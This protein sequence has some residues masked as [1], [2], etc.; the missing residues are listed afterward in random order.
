M[1]TELEPQ[2]IEAIAQRVIEK[3]KPMLSDNGKH[4]DNIV[5]NKNSLSEYLNVSES[6]I[7]KLISNK[8]IPHFKIQQGQ[9]G[10]VRFSKKDIDRWIQR[11]T[12][13]EI[14]PF[15]IKAVS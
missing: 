12:I 11:H 10:G 8:Q 13:P 7:N 4:E 9:S 14:N 15:T 5:F 6:T 3:L 2:D 1:K